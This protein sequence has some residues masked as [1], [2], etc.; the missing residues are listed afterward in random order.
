MFEFAAPARIIFGA[1]ALQ[2]IGSVAARFGTRALVV[3][4]SSPVRAQ[5]L[6]SLLTEHKIAVTV[7]SVSGEPSVELARQGTQLGRDSAAEMIIAMGGG[8][9]LDTG[10]AIAALLTNPGDPLDYLEVIG[11]GQ[12]ITQQSA[13]FIAIPTTA[14]T[15]SEVTSNAVL[16]SESHRVKVSLR[17]P[18]MLA[19]VA[20]IDP[21]LT[22]SSPPAVTAQSGLDALTQVIEPFVSN[23]ANPMTDALCRDGIQRA[24][25]S[26]RLAYEQPDH[27]AA[28][29]DMALTSLYG[30]FALSNAKL[31]AVHGFAGPFGGMFD[32]PHGAICARLLPF[33]IEANIRALRERAPESDA[34]RRYGEIA[35]MLTGHADARA[36]DAAIWADDLSTALDIAPLGR[37]G[38]TPDDYPTLIEKAAVASSMQGNPI[39]LTSDEMRHI[40]IAAQ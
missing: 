8:S 14:G 22:H 26:L 18:L 20:V 4:G 27:A 2:N 23:K 35:R 6:I 11:R 33:V 7:F 12:P 24:A 37:Y 5:S 31:G 40:L 39:K 32:A 9:V 36:E 3:T 29:E 16:A 21:T 10:K 38:I 15:G 30:G 17:S 25:R 34:L 1:G 19:R 28:R 13:P